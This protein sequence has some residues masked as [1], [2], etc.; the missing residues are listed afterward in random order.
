MGVFHTGLEQGDL[1]EDMA[2]G[3]VQ[4]EVAIVV[5][6]E[7][8]RTKAQKAPTRPPQA[9]G[10]CHIFEAPALVAVERVG[11][12]G[13]VGDKEIKVAVVV[14]VAKVH[15]HTGF[16][17]AV[18][19]KGRAHLQR[20][21]GKGAVP[22]VA[23]EIVLHA[24]VG[25]K[26]VLVAID[27]KVPSY[28]AQTLASQIRN[29]SFGRH[30]GKGAVAIVVEE[31]VGYA[32]VVGRRAIRTGALGDGQQPQR[33]RAH[34]A[35]AHFVGSERKIDIVDHVQVEVSVVIVVKK[36]RARTPLRSRYPGPVRH[37][38]KGAVAIVAV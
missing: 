10:L 34:K 7:E 3:H 8:I 24:V 29:A 32:S 16:V 36:G 21:I 37:I 33:G 9:D 23:E 11:L 1:V 31:R 12:V 6:V 25:D 20:D 17:V 22:L 28:H 30:V 18:G 5:V 27:V 15:P 2:I 13:K 35:A 38:G 26:H 14:V 4:V 19:V